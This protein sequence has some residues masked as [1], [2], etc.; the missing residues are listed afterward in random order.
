MGVRGMNLGMDDEVIGM[1]MNTQGESLLIVSERG[2]GK[3]TKTDEFT[4]QKRGGKGVKC[5]K[6][7]GKTG[8]II[9]VKAVN[10]NHEIM[11]ITTQGIIIQLKC[12]DIST[13]GRI[14]SGVK[15][16]NLD[17][18]ED[19]TV[20]SIAKVRDAVAQ[21]EEALRRLVESEGGAEELEDLDEI[22]EIDE[23]NEPGEEDEAEETAAAES[24]DDTP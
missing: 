11:M 16:I 20:A 4:V 18:R 13:Y 5:Y 14:T 23:A 7:T 19:I 1:Q 15:L 2:M 10:D 9:G 3:R 22:E 8:N 17:Q 24:E 6:I 12:D 21:T